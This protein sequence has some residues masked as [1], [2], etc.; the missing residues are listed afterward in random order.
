MES[1]SDEEGDEGEDIEM[2][3]TGVVKFDLI[4]LKKEKI[5]RSKCAF[6]AYIEH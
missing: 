5:P 6:N 2:E 3:D 1:D 4:Q